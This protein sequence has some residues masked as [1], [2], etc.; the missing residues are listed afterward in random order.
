M[1]YLKVRSRSLFTRLQTSHHPCV[2]TLEP[3]VTT[4]PHFS[5]D[6]DNLYHH[7]LYYLREYALHHLPDLLTETMCCLYVFAHAEVNTW[8]DTLVIVAYPDQQ[9]SKCKGFTYFSEQLLPSSV[10]ASDGTSYVAL[11]INEIN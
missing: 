3:Q 6:R 5:S 8:R 2:V 1:V 9:Y 7:W 11:F 4:T 10:V